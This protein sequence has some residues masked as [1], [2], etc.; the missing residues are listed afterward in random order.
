MDN[1]EV[2]TKVLCDEES[3]HWDTYD[4]HKLVFYR[5]GTGEITS[6]AELCIWIVAIFE[7]K[8]HDPAT[9]EYNEPV[10]LAQRSF[11]QGLISRSPP[12]P[13]LLRASIDFKLTKRRPLLYGKVVEHRI[14]EDVLLDAA[15]EPRVLGITVERGHFRPSWDS[16]MPSS[17][18]YQVQLS[19][20]VSPYPATEAWRPAQHDMVKSMGQPQMTQFCARQLAREERTGC[21][22]M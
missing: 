4:G 3:W 8:V 21:I 19:F 20:D 9:V 22:L 6:L 15:F 18:Y 16:G 11:V 12:P 14:N 7:W 10:P 1:S 2:V 13:P 5:D 17:L